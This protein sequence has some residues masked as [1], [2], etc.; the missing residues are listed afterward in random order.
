[1]PASIFY[2]ISYAA[3]CAAIF[4]FPKTKGDPGK[5]QNGF[6]WLAIALLAA[7]CW[8]GV[9]AGL[10]SLLHI[11]VTLISVGAAHLAAAACLYLAARQ[12]GMAPLLPLQATRR[13]GMAPLRTLQAPRR[14]GTVLASCA[15][16][17][18]RV[19]DIAAGVLLLLLIIYLGYTRFHTANPIIFAT[20]DPAERLGNAMNI[21]VTK[22]VI[23]HFPNQYFIQLTGSLFIQTLQPFA[24][25]VLPFR[26]FE[27]K[28]MFNLWFTGALF[29]GA[30]S[31]FMRSRFAKGA[32]FIL[33]FVFLL[34][35]PW[36]GQ[37]FGFVY[38]GVAVNLILLVLI[39]FALLY[40]GELDKRPAYLLIS[41]GCFGLGIC[42]TL[43]APPVFLAAF[44]AIFFYERRSGEARIG[45]IALTELL[46]FI[47]PAVWTFVNSV[48][49][50]INDEFNVGSS[51]T[52]EGAIYRNLFTDFLPYAPLA[53]WF[54]WRLISKKQWNFHLL[55]TL[56]FAAYQIGIFALMMTFRVSTYYYYKLYFATWL[57]FLFMACLAIDELVRNSRVRRFVAVYG[58]CWA[59]AA[60]LGVS[61]ADYKLQDHRFLSNEQPGADVSFRIYAQNIQYF[62][63]PGEYNY[64]NYDKYFIKL[65]TEARRLSGPVNEKK[66]IEIVTEEMKDVFWKDALT[67]QLLIPRYGPPENKNCLWIVLTDSP[68][69]EKDKE[70]YDS[71]E[72]LFENRLGYVVKPG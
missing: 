45:R 32:C 68:A 21:A 4:G 30:A 8:A 70:Y 22:S 52:E 28:D 19:L 24:P 44:L 50:D 7:E 34:G 64:I 16:P 14:K 49:L 56:C 31:L 58:V 37:L 12:E 69:Y 11:P 2:I 35:F 63:P 61:G 60:A 1:M 18:I 65:C 55:F 57:I 72:R 51:I 27:W 6:L 47:I 9:A 15:V 53:I 39:A 41:L 40:R 59:L 17:E 54:A 20:I 13:K 23:T 48:M 42:Y 67:S 46:I 62:T 33:T 38:P 29:Y 26:F 36:M 10:M 66:H 25:S 71:L 3:L 5:K 43:Y